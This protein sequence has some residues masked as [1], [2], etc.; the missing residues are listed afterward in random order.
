ML[1]DADRLR[2]TFAAN[3]RVQFQYRRNPVEGTIARTNPRKAVV[4]V[5]GEDYSV[6]YELLTPLGSTGGERQKQLA[7]VAKL[8]RD[9]MDEHGLRKWSFRFDHSTR[10]AGSC[11]YRNKTL[12]IAFELA[13]TGTDADIRDTLLHEIA[14]ALVGKKHNHDEVWRTKAQEIGCSGERTH[15]LSFSPPRYSVT[16]ENNCWTHTA[17]RRNRNLLC[18]RCGGK[19]IYTAG[20]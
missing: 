5:D 14:H 17:E 10:R 15:R 18:R 9:L 6:P 3:D 1:N 11:D 2:A 12:T 16:C 13:R 8:A 7:E 20:T 19:L 4:R